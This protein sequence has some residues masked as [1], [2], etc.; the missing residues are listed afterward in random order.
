[1]SIPLELA[2]AIDALRDGDRGTDI[3]KQAII[4]I[5]AMGIGIIVVRTLSRVLFFT[6]GRLMEFQLKND[7]F[8][9]LMQQQPSFYAQWQTGDIIARSSEDL[10]FVRVMVGFGLLQIFN[11]SAALL[12]TG[13]QM[14]MLSWQLTL[15]SLIP[16]VVTLLIVQIGT[17]YIYKLIRRNR[18]EMSDLSEH[19]LSSIHGVQTIQGFRAEE[20]FLQR[21]RER[22]DRYLKTLLQMAN[23]RAWLFPLFVLGAGICIWMLLAIGGPMTIQGQLTVGQIVAFVTYITYLLAPLRSLG[24]LMS[25]F[26]Q[27]YTSLDRIFELL[28][29]SPE[30]PEGKTPMPLPDQ[31]VCLELRDLSFAYPDAPNKDILSHISVDIPAGSWVGIFGRTG[32]G[33]STLL[34]LIARLYNSPP[35]SIFANGVDITRVDLDRW[36]EKIAVVSQTPFLF[37]DSIAEN[38]C[39]ST[40]VDRTRLQQVIHWAALTRDIQDMPEGIDTIVGERGIMVSGGQRQRVT[41]ARALYRDFELLILDDILSAI[42]HHTEHQLIDMLRDLAANTS[43][44]V[45][46]T[47][48]LVSHRISALTRCDQILVLENGMISERGTHAELIERPG[49]YRDTWQHQTETSS[50]NEHKSIP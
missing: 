6:P 49:C 20:A 37:S 29:N 46:P 40:E 9:R 1:V 5:A 26:Q 22:N 15:W 44:S 24:W 30:R 12:M 31:P 32:S 43:R 10:S 41:L 39:M 3:V 11:T 21:F 34:R 19:I 13:T 17:Y 14:L 28:N 16:I 23:L 47:I 42:D 8:A 50:M 38:I 18:Q 27:G 33:K 36:R 7:L 4:A 35:Q 2:S 45:P 48:I 25:V